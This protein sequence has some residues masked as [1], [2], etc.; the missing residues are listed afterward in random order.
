MRKD[1]SGRSPGI[2][3][4][5]LTWAVSGNQI[6]KLHDAGALFG[7]IPRRLFLGAMT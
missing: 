7:P 5:E 3:F 4:S 2:I 6:E 1:E